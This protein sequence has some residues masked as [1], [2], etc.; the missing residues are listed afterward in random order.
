MKDLRASPAEVRSRLPSPTLSSSSATVKSSNII[1]GILEN[2]EKLPGRIHA[3]FATNARGFVGPAFFFY[4]RGKPGKEQKAKK[5]AVH[6][7][8]LRGKKRKAAEPLSSSSSASPV[9]AFPV[10]SPL[11]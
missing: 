8:T 11:P 3:L 4:T 6:S 7:E 10:P 5:K 1:E 2:K 9:S